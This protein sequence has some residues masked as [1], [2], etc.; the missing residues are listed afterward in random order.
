[1]T[2]GPEHP[3]PSAAPAESQPSPVA[4]ADL[5]EA[6]GRYRVDTPV[7]QGPLDGLVALAQRGEGDRAQGPVGAGSAAYRRVLDA[8]EP[9]PEAREVADVLTMASRLVT[10]KAQRLLPDGPLELDE[11]AE[12]ELSE[13]V[14]PGSRLAEYLL[15]REAAEALLSEV[16]EQ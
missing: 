14:D 8:S 3:S 2:D 1:M 16:S 13:E 12:D 11:P 7:Y 6:G 15:F 10:L 9:K 4:G 5:T